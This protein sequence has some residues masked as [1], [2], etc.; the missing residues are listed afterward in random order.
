MDKAFVTGGSGFVGRNL[1][2]ELKR[3]GV[4]VAA[5]ARSDSAAQAVRDA[6]ADEAVRAG[7]GDTAL[8]AAGMR[9]CDVVFHAAA[10]VN[11]WGPAKDF[12][13]VNVQGTQNVIDAAKQAGVPRLV[14]VSTEAVLAG[15]PPIVHADETWPYPEHPAGLYPLTKGLAEQRVIAAN[16]P[17]LTTVAVRPPLIWGKGDT[18]VLPQIATAVKSGQWYWFGGGNY[19]HTTTHVANVVEGLLLAAEKG[20]GGEI[21]FVTD[22]PPVIFKGFITAQLAAI[23]VKPGNRSMPLWLAALIANTTEPLWT[24][25][26]LTSQPP[27]PRTA[28]HVLA[29]ELICDDSK[30]RREL[31]YQGKMS[32]EAGLAELP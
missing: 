11:L 13:E 12:H 5:L 29:Q 15:G 6:G 31:G 21:Y 16:G 20:R 7:L 18:S 17:D 24:L 2:A 23:G 26:G 10:Y 32:V 4:A 30:A 19:L 8:M 14:H 9:G 27:L 28:I 1:I 22:G 25:L 3:Q